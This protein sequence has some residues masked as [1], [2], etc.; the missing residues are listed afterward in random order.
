MTGIF[1]G[2]ENRDTGRKKA[3][4]TQRNTNTEGRWPEAKNRVMLSQTKEHLEL[5]ETRKN[6]LPGERVWLCQ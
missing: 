6:S 3:G 4:E 5:E 1:I 2:R